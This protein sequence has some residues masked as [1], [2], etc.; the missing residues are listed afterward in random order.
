MST[1]VLPTL[2]DRPE[3]ALK[4]HELLASMTYFKDK[5]FNHALLR[6]NRLFLLGVKL[7]ERLLDSDYAKHFVVLDF[8]QSV[9]RRNC[10]TK[11]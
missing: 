3:W 9:V 6:E 10:P 2:D 1:S 11:A 7:A 4:C 5:I 8:A